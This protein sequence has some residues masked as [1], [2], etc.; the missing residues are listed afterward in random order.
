MAKEY[1]LLQAE[2]LVRANV[3]VVLDWGFWTRS[4]RL[5]IAQRFASAGI[6]VEWMQTNIDQSTWEAYIESRNQSVKNGTAKDYLIDNGLRSK[7]LERFEPL[8]E[9]ELKLYATF[10]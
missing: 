2:K 4:E 3:D 9:D 10:S 1:L 5:G 8:T 7:A 6:C